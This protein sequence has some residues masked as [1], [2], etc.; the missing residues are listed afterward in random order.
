MIIRKPEDL[1]AAWEEAHGVLESDDL[2]RRFLH[3]ECMKDILK[4]RPERIAVA[5]KRNPK[6]HDV[7]E[8]LYAQD[9]RLEEFLDKYYPYRKSQPEVLK[10]QI[11]QR[12]KDARRW[13][14]R[15]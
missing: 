12:E 5:V 6:L 10:S 1:L 11:E 4:H 7:L 2:R 14:R 15:F 3:H 9:D 8:D 13:G